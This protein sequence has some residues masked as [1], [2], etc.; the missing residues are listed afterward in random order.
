MENRVFAVNLKMVSTIQIGGHMIKK[1]SI[2]WKSKTERCVPLSSNGSQEKADA[3][4]HF[5]RSLSRDP[6]LNDNP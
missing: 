3:T 5:C 6:L 2:W 4:C 1:K